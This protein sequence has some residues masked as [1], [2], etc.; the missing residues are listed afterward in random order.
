MA[1]STAG[2]G[3]LLLVDRTIH[4]V[5]LFLGVRVQQECPSLSRRRRVAR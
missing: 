1:S 5:A 3:V 4:I 2:L